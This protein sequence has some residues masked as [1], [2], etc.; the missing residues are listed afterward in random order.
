MSFFLPAAV[1][2]FFVYCSVQW[3]IFSSLCDVT[4]NRLQMDVHLLLLRANAGQR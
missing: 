4:L 3:L 1:V 2:A